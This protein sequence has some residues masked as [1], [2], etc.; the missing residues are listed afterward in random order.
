MLANVHTSPYEYTLRLSHGGN[1]GSNPLGDA[2]LCNGLVGAGPG[3]SYK[4]GIAD[5]A[6]EGGTGSAGPSCAAATD[7]FD[8][9]V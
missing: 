9:L 7:P 2:N 6:A 5:A 1:R 3:S 8:E 4:C